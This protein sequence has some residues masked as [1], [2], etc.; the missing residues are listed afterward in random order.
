MDVSNEVN[1]CS[2][3]TFDNFV[4]GPCNRFAY[5]ASLE[6]A[7]NISKTP[8]NPLFLFGAPGLGKTHLMHAI[9]NYILKD[10]PMSKV[11]H[12]TVEKFTNR[13]INAIKDDGMSEFKSGFKVYDVLL[14]DDL[15]FLDGKKYTQEMLYFIINDLLRAGKL[16]VLS[17]TKPAKEIEVFD[18]TF[19]SI[20]DIGL[21]ADIHAPDL[22]TRI[23]ILK[24]L[25]ER[26]NIIASDK[27][28]IYLAG[29]V[30]TNIRELKTA[31]NRVVAFSY[32]MQ[33]KLNLKL[34][35]QAMKNF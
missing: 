18:R 35:K 20:F 29:R 2:E 22:E 27:V 31:F 33:E 34:A 10:K 7:K 4:T 1:I 24:K 21:V 26:E 12:I 5:A 13:L 32:L 30:D 6:V 19:L 14:I 16:I 3:L 17:S 25:S 23:S 11:M 9:G 8:Y 15:Q 28:I